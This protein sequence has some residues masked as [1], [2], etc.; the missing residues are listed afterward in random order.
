MKDLTDDLTAFYQP[1]MAL[2]FYK[3]KGR[4]AEMFVESYDIDAKGSPI[5]AHPLSVREAQKL[6]KALQVGSQADRMLKTS[7]ILGT[8]ILYTDPS[9]N[10]VIWFTRSTRRKMYFSDLLGIPNGMASVPP[11]LWCA[12]RESLS[13]YALG[14]DRRPNERTKLYHAPFF[15]IYQSGNV[16]M[17]TVDVEIGTSLTIEQ[18]TLAWEEY[19]FNSYF[20]HL[21]EGHNPVEGNCVMLWEDL[22][23]GQG[24]FPMD[25]L[26]R[27]GTTIKDLI[28]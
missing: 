22:V 5:N 21:L 9:K 28:Q 3:G 10:K 20:N 6:V 8:H 18:F 7:G 13:V 1:K 15:N 24:T 25:Q 2:L 19:F 26:K 23:D 12:D 27:T 17:G 16:C 4:H 14:N 11:M